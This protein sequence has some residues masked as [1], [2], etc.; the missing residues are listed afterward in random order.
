MHLWAH[1]TP[2]ALLFH[3]Q[4]KTKS[5]DSSPVLPQP[6]AI[7]STSLPFN[8]FIQ[9]SKQLLNPIALTKTDFS[10]HLSMHPY[11]HLLHSALHFHTAPLN[12]LS[13]KSSSLPFSICLPKKNFLRLFACSSACCDLL[14]NHHILELF[15]QAILQTPP[16]R[17]S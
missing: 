7:L 13:T 8:M 10:I 1:L 17:Q 6:L 3:P 12:L 9:K 16:F 2:S 11:S 15:P 14:K 5:K 4:L